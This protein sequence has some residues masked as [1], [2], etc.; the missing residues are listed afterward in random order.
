MHSSLAASR[1]L[2]SSGGAS[3]AMRHP[4]PAGGG[5]APVG[6]AHPEAGELAL[7]CCGRLEV[8][9]F[10][11]LFEPGEPE[12][13]PI[14]LRGN[15]KPHGQGAP[16][17]RGGY[18]L[19]RVTWKPSSAD[20]RS[21]CPARGRKIRGVEEVTGRHPDATQATP[22]YTSKS[23][24]ARRPFLR[25]CFASSAVPFTFSYCS[26]NVGQPSRVVRGTPIFLAI[27]ATFAPLIN[28]S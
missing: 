18:A 15:G 17:F 8:A 4:L 13:G 26:R 24:P 20:S 21:D 6:N 23:S 25:A 11:R 14:V 12:E 9:L 1:A 7:C 10:Q 28:N 22:S 5:G 19:G 27:A 2:T 3:A 16:P